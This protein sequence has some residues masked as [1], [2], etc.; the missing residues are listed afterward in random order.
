MFDTNK[1]FM[2]TRHVGLD[3]TEFCARA[4]D[5]GDRLHL[6]LAVL[7]VIVISLKHFDSRYV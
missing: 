7:W 2:M 4:L 5:L 1:C 3:F 6:V